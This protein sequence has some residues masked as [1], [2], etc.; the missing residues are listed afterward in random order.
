[1]PCLHR[2]LVPLLLSPEN[3]GGIHKKPLPRADSPENHPNLKMIHFCLMSSMQ[4]LTIH[5]DPQEGKGGIRILQ[6]WGRRSRTV[7]VLVWGHLNFC[8]T[9]SYQGYSIAKKLRLKGESHPPPLS[10][11]YLRLRAPCPSLANAT[12]SGHDSPGLQEGSA[13]RQEHPFCWQ[14]RSSQLKTTVKLQ[15]KA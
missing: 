5:L 7:V 14:L 3:K 8:R 4:R 12:A 11:G 9:N 10:A 13:A 6:G 15:F 1:M 2:P